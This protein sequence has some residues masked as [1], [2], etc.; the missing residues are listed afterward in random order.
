MIPASDFFSTSTSSDFF[1]TSTP[2]RVS[3][4]RFA[5]LDFDTPFFFFKPVI[6]WRADLTSARGT[7]II[8]WPSSEIYDWRR[9]GQNGNG[10]CGGWWW[11]RNVGSWHQGEGKAR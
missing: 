3:T 4:P 11:R 8:G 2:S 9:M 6:L 7:W 10:E 1:S 5:F